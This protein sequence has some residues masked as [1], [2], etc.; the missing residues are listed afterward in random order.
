MIWLGKWQIHETFTWDVDSGNGE[1]IKQEESH[2]IVTGGLVINVLRP[3]TWCQELQPVLL[4]HFSYKLFILKK[5]AFLITTN[6]TDVCCRRAFL[7]MEG[8]FSLLARTYTGGKVEQITAWIHLGQ[9]LPFMVQT[10][11]VAQLYLWLYLCFTPQDAV[12]SFFTVN[13][14]LIFMRCH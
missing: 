14:H 7:I 13:E 2:Q 12:T 8:F 6:D 10:V 3:F 9:K 11:T 5:S 1:H 4:F